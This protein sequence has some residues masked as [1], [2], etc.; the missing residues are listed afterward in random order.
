MGRKYIV[1]VE[2]E[3]QIIIEVGANSTGAATIASNPISFLKPYTELDLDAIRKEAYDKGCE[4][5]K[6]EC[7][8][9][10]KVMADAEQELAE[11]AYQRGLN[12]AWAVARKIA[13]DKEDGG[14]DTVAY[15]ET[16]GYGKGFGAVL[17]TFTASEAVEKIR[18]YEQEK[19]KQARIEY[20][21]DEI[22]DV[23]N[24]TM[25]ECNVSLDDIA[26][27]LQKM[28]ETE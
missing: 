28:K 22:K 26:E 2:D 1:E 11:K 23:L 5:A 24:T 27:V 16:F 8:Q 21:C 14:L 7:E 12:D 10:R 3:T 18:Q 9:C 25:K 6:H 20:N 17:K 15:C 19:D 13:L 4:T